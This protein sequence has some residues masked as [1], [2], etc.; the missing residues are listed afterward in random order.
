LSQ[1]EKH[2]NNTHGGIVEAAETTVA[3]R[4]A[5]QATVNASVDGTTYCGSTE[6]V[7]GEG[8]DR[9]YSPELTA[10]GIR[11]STKCTNGVLTVNVLPSV[12]TSPVQR[13]VPTVVGLPL[14]SPETDHRVAHAG[15][16]LGPRHVQQRVRDCA[17]LTGHGRRRFS[18]AEVQLLL[19]EPRVAS[20]VANRSVDNDVLRAVLSSSEQMA[21]LLRIHGF[22]PLRERVRTAY[23]NAAPSN[24]SSRSFVVNP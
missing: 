4:K 5:L 13:V 24:P 23:R 20:M 9:A 22:W 17:L 3:L 1:A 14:P 15:P 2:Y 18:P 8:G 21:G 6:A 10:D 16:V 11:C 7:H 12:T 19:G